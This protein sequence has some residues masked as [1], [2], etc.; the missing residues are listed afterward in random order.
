MRQYS[1]DP[2]AVSA[3]DSIADAQEPPPIV[4]IVVD[5][6]PAVAREQVT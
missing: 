5:R 4:V 2:P 1:V 3:H 6:L